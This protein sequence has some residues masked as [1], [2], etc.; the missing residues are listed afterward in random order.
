[1]QQTE[2]VRSIE[3]RQRHN[4]RSGKGF[5]IALQWRRSADQSKMIENQ[6]AAMSPVE[7]GKSSSHNAADHQPPV[8]KSWRD[9][10]IS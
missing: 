7:A 4:P 3:D 2:Q 6:S 9:E 1:M 10:A 8:T 5:D